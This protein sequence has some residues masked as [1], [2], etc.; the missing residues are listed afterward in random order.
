V[1]VATDRLYVGAIYV[2]DGATGELEHTYYYYDGS[3]MYSLA[4]GDVDHDGATEIVAGGGTEHT[5]SAGSSVY[6]IDGATGAVEWMSAPLG[7]YWSDIWQVAVAQ[8]DDDPALEIVALD[9]S[10]Y[11]FDGITHEVWQSPL[12]TYTSM[13]LFDVQ[14]DS[15]PEILLGT[16]AGAIVGFEP[17][18]GGWSQFMS[19]AVASRPVVGLRGYQLQGQPHVVFATDGDYWDSVP[20]LL[21][22]FRL[23][24]HAVIWQSDPLGWRVGEGNGLEVAPIATDTGTLFLVGSSYS[25]HQYGGVN[26]RALFEDGFESGDTAAWSL[27]EP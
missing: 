20:A 24:D 2:F 26:P 5:G 11:V 16:S 9:E 6:V 19:Y 3:P 8:L 27:T 10:F 17:Q 21:R 23:S 1:L 4:I 18:A 12:A 14:G 22:G 7:S 13:D 15:N 25:V